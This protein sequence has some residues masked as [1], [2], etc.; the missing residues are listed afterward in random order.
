MGYTLRN[1]FFLLAFGL[2]AVQ[3]FG[4]FAEFAKE[5]RDARVRRMTEQI[6]AQDPGEAYGGGDQEMVLRANPYGHFTVAAWIDGS[7]IPFM[8]DTG[9]STVVLS[10]DAADRLGIHPSGLDYDVVFATANGEVHA[11][12]VTLPELR[13]GDLELEDVEAAVIEV[14][15][16]ISLLGM[17]ALDRLAGFE[18]QGDRMIL[19]W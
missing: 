7:E 3:G 18:V 15:M 4:H 11:A 6:T 10:P 17:T 5:D 12:L 14:P 19:R 13:I 2:L 8:I 1:V 16:A 9:A